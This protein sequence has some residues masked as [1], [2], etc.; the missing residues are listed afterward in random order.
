MLHFGYMC[1]VMC[2]LFLFARLSREGTENYS[3]RHL[4][5]G[6]GWGWARESK[7]IKKKKKPKQI[8]VPAM[9]KVS[10][11]SSLV[12]PLP[13]VPDTPGYVWGLKSCTFPPALVFAHVLSTAWEVFFTSTPLHL[14]FAQST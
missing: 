6:E 9:S 5:L 13:C 8:Q 2:E 7:T 3:S 1:R 10:T 4:L 12:I 11:T 14:Q